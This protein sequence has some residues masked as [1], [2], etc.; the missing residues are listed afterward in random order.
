MGRCGPLVKAVAQALAFA[1]SAGVLDKV[2]HIPVPARPLCSGVPGVGE[3]G[4]LDQT[5]SVG[6]GSAAAAKSPKTGLPKQFLRERRLS[7]NQ[8]R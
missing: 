6:R 2:L 3:I 1:P 8:N 5:D 7:S 4:G